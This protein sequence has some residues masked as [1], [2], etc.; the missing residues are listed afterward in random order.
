MEFNSPKAAKNTK[1]ISTS[2][3]LPTA[4]NSFHTAIS[5]PEHDKHQD[6]LYSY[7]EIRNRKT[8]GKFTTHRKR[9][10][11]DSDLDSLEFS[12]MN[13]TCGMLGHS[14][15]KKSD[16]FKIKFKT[17]LCKFWQLDAVCKYGENVINHIQ[18][19]CLFN[20]SALLLMVSMK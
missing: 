3:N 5:T 15:K 20:F 16:D 2:S 4:N 13:S 7:V 6:E 17:E 10:N 12:E 14:N 18:K 9:S 8:S 1:A 11:A 19:L